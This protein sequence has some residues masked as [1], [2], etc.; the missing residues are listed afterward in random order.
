[1]YRK[2]GLHTYRAKVELS[3]GIW[4]RVFTGHFEDPEQA[5]TFRQKHGLTEATVK[6]TQYANL[7]GIYTPSDELEEKILS[8][9]NLGYFPYLIKDHEGKSRLFVGA[10]ITKQPTEKLQYDLKSH[11]IQS[12]VVKR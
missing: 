1:M 10:F 5:E 9:K 6:K 3:N 7:I 11:G 8:L 12:Q 2:M 4:Y